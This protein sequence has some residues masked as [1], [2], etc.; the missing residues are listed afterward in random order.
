LGGFRVTPRT[1][2]HSHAVRIATRKA[3]LRR[4][5]R[6]LVRSS[7]KRTPRQ[8]RPPVPSS[9]K[10]KKGCWHAPHPRCQRIDIRKKGER[11]MKSLSVKSLC[12]CTCGLVAAL[13]LLAPASAQTPTGACCLLDGTCVVAT[14]ADCAAQHGI[15]RGD[16]SACSAVRCVARGACCL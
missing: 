5:L 16:N 4:I 15:Y 3:A 7:Q 10:Q 6:H 9:R 11:S 2:G 14:Q 12:Q 1:H 13:I 8:A